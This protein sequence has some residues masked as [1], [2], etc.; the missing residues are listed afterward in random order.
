MPQTATIRGIV[1]VAALWLACDGSRALAQ[2]VKIV[3]TADT[4]GH[5]GPC[6]DCPSQAGRGGLA[7]RAVLFESFRTKGPSLFVDAGNFLFGPDSAAS[8]GKIMADAYAALRYDVVNLSHYELWSGKAALLERLQGARLAAVSANLLDAGSK[9]PIVAP[10]VVKESGGRK[11]AFLGLV[12]PPAGVDFLPRLGRQLQDVTVRAPAQ[13]LAEWL[14]KAQAESNQVIVLYYGTTRGLVAVRAAAAG[15]VAAIVVGGIRPEQVPAGQP[16]ALAAEE[17]GKAVAS[18]TLEAAG[19][20]RDAGPVPIEPALAPDPAIEK[21]VAAYVQA[22]STS[23]TTPTG[24]VAAVPEPTLPADPERGRIFPLRRGGSNRAVRLTIQNAAMVERY[25]EATAAPGGAILVLGT[26]WENTIPLSLIQQQ[27]V[28]TLYK[29]PNL[30]D[31]VYLVVD[32]RRLARLDPR[33]A[34]LP[35]HVPVK[36]FTLEQI[37]ARVR[38][39]LVFRLPPGAT[40]GALELRYYDFAHG[41][42]VV[43]LRGASEGAVAGSAQAA[44]PATAPQKN[45]VLEVGVYAVRSDKTLAGRTAPTGVTFLSVDLRARSLF[46]TDADATAFDPKARPGTT[47]KLGYVADWKESRKYLQLVADG[48][49]AYMPEPQATELEEEPRFLPDVMTGGNVVFLAP[50]NATSLELRCDFPNAKAST[51]GGTFRPKGLTIPLEGSRPAMRQRPA[52]A[53]VDDD[54]YRISVVGQQAVDTFAGE[55]PPAEA[56]FVVLDVTVANTGNR[57]GEFFQTKEQLKYVAPAGQQSELS[58]VT[59]NGP[60]RPAELVWIP[61]GERRTF[62]AVFEVPASETRPRLAFRGV[63]KAEVLNLKPLDA[64]TV[65]AAPAAPDVDSPAAPAAKAPMKVAANTNPPAANATSPVAPDAPS[66]PVRTVPAKKPDLKQ[67]ADAKPTRVA[68]MQPLEPKGLAGVGVTAEQVN[69]AIDRGAEALWTHTMAEMKG[70]ADEFGRNLGYDA[71]VGLALVHANYHR[72]SPEF[73]AALR[74]MLSRVDPPQL[75]TYGAGI[76]AMLIESYGDGYYLPKLRQTVRCIV[77]SQGPAGSWG[78][79]A[80][81]PDELLRDPMADR[82]LQVRGGLPLEGAGALG[83]PIKRVGKMEPSMDG[84]NSTSQYALLGLW[85]AAR[86]KVPVEPEVWKHALA[87]Y[88]ARQCNDGGWH[89]ASQGGF[90]YGSMTCAGV[91]SIA[92]A[93]HHLG[94]AAP[95]EDEAVERGL[96]W[97]ANH[98][99]VTKHPESSESHLYYYLY[100]LERVGRVLDTEFIGPH[101]WYPLGAKYLLAQQKEDGN[102]KGFG[103]EEKPTLA[104]S[105]SLLFLTRATS[106]LNVEQKRGGNGKLRTDVAVAPGHRVYIIL[107]CSGSMLP[108]MGGT[109]KFKAARDAVSALIDELPDNAEVALRAYGHRKNARQEGADQD[110]ELVLP[111]QKLNRQAFMAKLNTLR[112]RG[113]TPLALSL[114]E[115]ARDVTSAARDK[116]KPVTLVLLTDGGEDTRP[117]QDPVAAAKELSKLEGLNFQIVGFD[118]S[119]ADWDEQLQAMAESGNGVYIPA[120]EADTLLRDLRSAVFRV[121]DT[122]V[123]T[124]AKGQ[125]VMK[126]QFGTTKAL[127]EGK[128][129]FSTVFGGKRY[130]QDFWINTDA[131]TAVVFDAAKIATDKNGQEVAGGV[132]AGNAARGTRRPAAATEDDAAVDAAR[133]ANP[134]AR[135]PAGT[136][137]AAKKRFCT[138][139]GKPLSP[140]AKFCPN[141]GAKVAG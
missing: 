50:E 18:L 79:T 140:G 129:S 23:P 9:Q 121:P 114:R 113:K 56:R 131:T 83:E 101:E 14:P 28:P 11:I 105:F 138:E 116:D 60:R 84:D 31:H 22:P 25:A 110:T 32:G 136:S 76:L 30:E 137:A 5:V 36:D 78:Y 89:Y 103:E 141:C 73:D 24:H 57:N 65:A 123:V 13:A 100:S 49:Y 87:V 39:N 115:A 29:V 125:P 71:L 75:G 38:G 45:E 122:F 77:E 44:R 17:H 86:A 119:R 108:E 43:P 74:G 134:P 112:P 72:K 66:T 37:G 124:T 69:A 19:T 80:R 20:A 40:G 51:G 130:S 95:A 64:T 118:I 26:E 1:F 48:E 85:A 70:R 63:S 132:G 10:Y 33:A 96:A 2:P 81:A 139:C 93:R 106:S 55:K 59:F 126:A 98:F 7:R 104:T 68:A 47:T 53:S 82:V 62:Q 128:Y 88:R 107:D 97:L 117:R 41:H 67:P 52:I 127:P 120:S 12:E 92:L 4:G 21:L 35:G 8:G 27:Q 6:D 90:G 109:Q 94:D 15:K 46:T 3:A 58:P 135:Q 111:M 16:L 102:W 133:P 99:T 34:A 42:M 61:P 54:V 91:C